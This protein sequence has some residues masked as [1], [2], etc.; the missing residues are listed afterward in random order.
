MTDI[1]STDMTA[2]LAA[3]ALAIQQ[4][5]GGLSSLLAGHMVALGADGK[6]QNFPLVGY[7][8]MGTTLVAASMAWRVQRGVQA[9]TRECARERGRQRPAGRWAPP[10]SLLR[11]CETPATAASRR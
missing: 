8:V 4:L 7:V 1:V 10:Q 11:R 2:W 9:R 5:A 3:K 6:I